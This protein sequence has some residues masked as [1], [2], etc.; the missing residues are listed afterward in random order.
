MAVDINLVCCCLQARFKPGK[1]EAPRDDEAEALEAEL[2]PLANAVL[3]LAL[4]L[5]V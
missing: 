5:I 1:F 2:A 4:Q 3:R